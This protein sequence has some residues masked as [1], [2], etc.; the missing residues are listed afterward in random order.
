MDN[1]VMIYGLDGATFKIINPLIEAGHLPNI[2]SMMDNGVRGVLRSTVPPITG[3]A[4]TSFLTGKKPERHGIFDFLKLNERGEQV[5][6]TSLDNRSLTLFDI[7]THYKKRTI[8]INIPMTYPPQKLN[9]ILVCGY[10]TPKN[11]NY[12]YPEDFKC[13]LESKDYLIDCFHIA[14]SSDIIK[15]IEAVFRAEKKRGEVVS[16]LVKDEQWDVFM[17]VFGGPDGICHW[18][19]EDKERIYD[20]YKLVDHI[21]GDLNQQLDESVYKIIMSDHGFVNMDFELFLN[22]WLEM[23]GY[24]HYVKKSKISSRM[25]VEA[26]IRKLLSFL[27]IDSRKLRSL[28]P[29]KVQ[30]LFP[31]ECWIDWK[32]TTAYTVS[33]NFWGININL[34]GREKEGIV[35]K[36]SNEYRTIKEDIADK[37]GK[38]INSYTDQPVFNKVSSPEQFYKGPFVENA[39]DIVMVPDGNYF[40]GKDTQGD[41]FIVELSGEKGFHDMDGI[42][43]LEGQSVASGETITSAAIVDLAPTILHIVDVPIPEDMDGKVQKDIFDQNSALYNR[44]IQFVQPVKIK[45]SRGIDLPTRDAEQQIE[46][47]LKSLGY[48]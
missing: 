19:W 32:K 1:K 48:M 27:K 39:P 18:A 10:P 34:K 24:L 7:L 2:K 43:I 40:N 41:D 25:P 45:S 16:N 6:A 3:P 4:W 33:H 46:E 35:D 47:K 44:E 8:A 30:S 36:Q 28:V 11:S 37:L 17:C 42:L 14:D 5:P 12:T 38:L 21:I 26:R 22:K 31:G 15:R 20:M 23:E 13:Y 29:T 9:G